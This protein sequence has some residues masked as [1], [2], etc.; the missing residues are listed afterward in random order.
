MPAILD[1]F[2]EVMNMAP[3][4]D[5]LLA[6]ALLCVRTPYQYGA[7]GADPRAFLTGQALATDC[8]GFVRRVFHEVF[9]AAGLLAR[10]DLNVA[11]FT[12]TDLF[13]N[14]TEPLVGD[15]IL[16]QRHMG[17]VSDVAN[18]RF[19]GAQSSTGVAMA[20]YGSGYWAAGIKAFRKWQSF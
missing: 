17:I 15:I 2:A 13:V 6:V 9:P 5:K 11:A 7:K 3:S 14:V 8:S 1:R 18:K 20:A 12:V 4:R 16:W 19:I 10:D